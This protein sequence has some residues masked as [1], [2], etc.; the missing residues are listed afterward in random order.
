MEN[1]AIWAGKEKIQGVGTE[2]L[3]FWASGMR[4]ILDGPQD[5]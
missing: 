2:E 3:Y 1:R 4:F 5:W